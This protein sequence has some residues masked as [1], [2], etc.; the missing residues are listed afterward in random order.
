[1]KKHLISLLISSLISFK[2]I[3]LCEQKI[4]PRSLRLL[5]TIGSL[6]G[7]PVSNDVNNPN[8]FVLLV[9]VVV[10]FYLIF[11]LLNYLIYG[12]FKARFDNKG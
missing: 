11:L 2:Y 9:V 5:Y 1:M 7:V 3:S 8:Y 12:F 10:G 6:L 4:L